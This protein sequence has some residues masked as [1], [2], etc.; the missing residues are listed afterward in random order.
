MGWFWDFTT[1]IF[2]FPL[3]ISDS[4]VLRG[5]W[6]LL[7]RMKAELILF[8][9]IMILCWIKKYM[10]IRIEIKILPTFSYL[11][12]HIYSLVFLNHHVLFLERYIA[13][14]IVSILPWGFAICRSE[15][16][17][18][19]RSIIMHAFSRWTWV[20]KM[21]YAMDRCQ[22]NSYVICVQ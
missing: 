2:H 10:D 7:I 14:D 8:K 4:Q 19:H 9:Y 22:K 18:I 1:K 3:D 12:S 5:I 16:S 11:A 20:D 21:L 13:M 15:L 17:L 6:I